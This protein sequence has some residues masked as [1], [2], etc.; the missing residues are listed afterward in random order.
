MPEF[1]ISAIRDRIA[2]VSRQEMGLSEAVAH[3]IGF[4]MTDWF[5]DFEDF[6][7]FCENPGKLSD[8]EVGRLLGTYLNHVPHH[9]AAAAKLYTGSPVSDVFGVGATDETQYGRPV[10][11]KRKK[12]GSR[13]SRK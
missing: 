5:D 4:H 6:S 11:L 3:D 9:L 2:E 12:G 13:E 8:K 1:D 7:Q 10:R